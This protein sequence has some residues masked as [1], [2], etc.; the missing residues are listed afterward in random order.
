MD[1]IP[2]NA[3]RRVKNVLLISRMTAAFP[4][5]HG[6][7]CPPWR[8][9]RPPSALSNNPNAPQGR[10]YNVYASSTVAARR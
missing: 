10:G 2:T 5:S 1:I 8:V 9:R 6:R 4:C 3:G 7:A